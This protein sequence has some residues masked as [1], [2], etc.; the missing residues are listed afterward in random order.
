M[1]AT[2]LNDE[3]VIESL[4]RNGIGVIPTD[5]IYGLVGSALSKS[6]VERIYQVKGRDP[7]KP[8]IVLI[9]QLSDVEGFGVN[10]DKDLIDK[11]AKF[12]PGKV[13]VI[14]N[15]PGEKFSYIHRGKDA[16]AFRLPAK[17]ELVD[18]I[19]K[20]G[21]LV[22]PSANPEGLIPA[23]SIEDARNYFGQKVDFYVDEGPLEETPSTLIGF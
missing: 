19:K 15:C 1:D 11:L 20:V 21:P 4:S 18:L 23:R 7:Q 16:I 6:A 5:T 3:G 9:G 8:L 13:S 2:S 14:L 10:L 22:S 17:Q 12:W